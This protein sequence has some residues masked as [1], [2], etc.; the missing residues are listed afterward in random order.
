[1]WNRTV[2]S[3]ESTQP[4]WTSALTPCCISITYLSDAR[5]EAEGSGLCCVQLEVEVERA[6]NWIPRVEWML[7]SRS[8]EIDS[9]SES[10]IQ[11]HIFRSVIQNHVL[12]TWLA[13]PTVARQLDGQTLYSACS[14]HIL[15]RLKPATTWLMEGWRRKKVPHASTIQVLRI[16]RSFF[17]DKFRWG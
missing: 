3:L 1:M 8:D 4:T 11:F 15:V 9:H 17:T 12:Q 7:L 2:P 16:G 14:G 6:A 13:T 5:D 10:V